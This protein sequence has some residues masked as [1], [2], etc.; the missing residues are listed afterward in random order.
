MATLSEED[1]GWKVFVWP[2]WTLRKCFSTHIKPLVLYVVKGNKTGLKADSEYAR[3]A[4]LGGGSGWVG[5]GVGHKQWRFI[6]REIFTD[7]FW[8]CLWYTNCRTVTYLPDRPYRSDTKSVQL[9][10]CSPAA[11]SDKPTNA[12]MVSGSKIHLGTKLSNTPKD[13]SIKYTQGQNTKYIREQ[14]YHL[15]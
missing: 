9:V 10:C 3:P 11:W 15:V 8:Y 12:Q 2:W 1:V 6:Y 14:K 4:K 7:S 13:R 5:R